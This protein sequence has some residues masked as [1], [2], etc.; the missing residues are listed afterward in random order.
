MTDAELAAVLRDAVAARGM[1]P[2]TARKRRGKPGVTLLWLRPEPV[3][4]RANAA[5]GRLLLEEYL[6][7]VVPGGR[8]H[9]RVKAF[10]A[11]RHADALCLSRNGNLTLGLPANGDWNG[12]LPRLL[13]VAQSLQAMLQVEWPDYATGTFAKPLV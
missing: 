7:F 4:L 2:G 6:P 1:S 5:R 13:A 12:T 9:R 11:E 8:L 10:L 3:T